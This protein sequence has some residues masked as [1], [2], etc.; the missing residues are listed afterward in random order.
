MFSLH[1]WRACLSSTFICSQYSYKKKIGSF[2]GLVVKP[3]WAGCNS[4]AALLKC[5]LQECVCVVLLALQD[6]TWLDMILSNSLAMFVKFTHEWRCIIKLWRHEICQLGV[7]GQGLAQVHFDT[8]TVGVRSTD[9][10]L[11]GQ[12]S[13]TTEQWPLHIVWYW[14]ER[15]TLFKQCYNST[16]PWPS[17]KQP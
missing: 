13:L 11:R 3:F 8:L 1:F 15:D 12:P 17:T 2:N 16:T 6:M 7:R 9:R 5:G 4:C 10:L 14:A